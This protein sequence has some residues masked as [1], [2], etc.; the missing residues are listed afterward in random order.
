[1]LTTSELFDLR[2]VS[3]P[4]DTL[5]ED[6]MPWQAIKNLDIFLESIEDERLGEI[7]PTAIVTG[8]VYIAPSAKIGPYVLVEGPAWLGPDT[9]VWHSAFLRPGVVMAEGSKIGHS[10]EVKHSILLNGAK[11]PHFNYVGD[12]V[13]GRNVNLGAGV[14]VA[15]FKTF[16]NTIKVDRYDTGLRKFGGAIGDDVSIGCNAVVAPGTLIGPR[17]VAYSG[18]ML[19][20]IYPADSVIK[21]SQ[22]QEVIARH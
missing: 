4:L 10:S 5:L 19:R 1:M 16:G 20:G 9:E 12:A 14:K 13:L 17:T 18:V 7:H 8:P 3:P 22:M 15:N 6:N 21:L 11:V 2:Q